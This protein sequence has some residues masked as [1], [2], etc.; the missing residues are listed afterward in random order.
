MFSH[1]TPSQ[2]LWTLPVREIMK[3]NPFYTFFFL[4]AFTAMLLLQSCDPT[5]SIRIENKTESIAIVNA[6]ITNNFQ[7]YGYVVKDL[8]QDSVMF[9]VPAREYIE[10]GTAI[11]GLSD[12]LPFTKLK[13]VSA[14]DSLLALSSEEVLELFE[15]DSWGD[16]ATPY[17][18]VIK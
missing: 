14:K 7:A 12:D 18:I 5:Y 2:I 4:C 9:E 13:I 16:L 17:R 10:L 15:K 6:L 11:G 3:T 1:A 8:A